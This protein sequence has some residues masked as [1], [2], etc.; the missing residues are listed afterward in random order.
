MKIFLET[1]VPIFENIRI[2][3]ICVVITFTQSLS[4]HKPPSM[5]Y[6]TEARGPPENFLWA[7]F[8]F[9]GFALAGFSGGQRA[10]AALCRQRDQ[11]WQRAHGHG[12]STSMSGMLCILS[13][14]SLVVMRWDS[15]AGRL[16]AVCGSNPASVTLCMTL[17]MAADPATSRPRCYPLTDVWMARS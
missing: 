7:E 12:G 8:L 11:V 5:N 6:R 16:H 14:L 9:V 10:R 1:L 3:N 15:R 13:I 17:K 4:P 2:I